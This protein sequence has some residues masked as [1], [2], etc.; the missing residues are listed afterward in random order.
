MNRRDAIARVGLLVGGTVVGANAFLAGC[1][2]K[3]TEEGVAGL[4][5]STENLGFLDE[6]GETIL[7]ETQ[8]S[9]GAKAAKIGEFMKAIVSDC[10]EETDQ[11]IFMDGITKLN[12]ASDEK[13]GNDFVS[14]SNEDRIKLLV[15]LDKEAK[16]HQKNKKK[17]DPQHYFTML[18]Q[19]TLWGYFT[20]EVGSTKALRYNPVPGRYEGCIDYKKGDKAWSAT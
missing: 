12:Q 7:P 13:F 4:N 2:P 11:K 5:F 20:S 15:E 8:A 9:P 18:K 14:L 10:Y 6:V 1:A 19:L 16:E 3:R 17:E